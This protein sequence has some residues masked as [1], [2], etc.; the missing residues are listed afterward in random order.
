MFYLASKVFWLI[1]QPSS[2]CLIAI[3]LGLAVLA[4]TAS[5]R[6]GLG[7]AFTGLAG[8][9]VA[10]FS[11]LGNIAVLPLEE[12]FANV[13][14]PASGTDITGIIILGG[15]E[16]GWVSAGRGGLGVNEA[17]ERLTEGVR[18]A[19]RYPDAKVIFTGGVA[20]LLAA[21][22][23][24][25]KAVGEYL[26]DVGVADDRIELEGRSRN[27]FQN[28]RFTHE[29]LSPGRDDIYLL[30]TSAY[31]M[32][33]SMGVF[34]SAGFNVVAAPVDFRTRDKGD[35]TRPFESMPSGLK[36]L[37]MASREWIGLLAYWLTGRTQ[38]LFPAP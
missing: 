10:G 4:F 21:Q 7:L 14:L 31:H 33:R 9:L 8:F 6:I 3:T 23:G 26:R 19:L 30:V 36:R 27:T 1:I 35:A 13:Q 16:D 25:A 29:M 28:A 32:P 37:D 17:A 5:R 2:L 38:D 24:G 20:G 11:P 15:F 12:R 18:L 22:A 34:R